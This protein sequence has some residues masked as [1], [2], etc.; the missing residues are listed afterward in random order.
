MEIK[1]IF[2]E[3]TIALELKLI[4]YGKDEIEDGVTHFNKNVFP[5][6]LRA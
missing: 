5:Q 4:V 3:H 2:Q 1:W 6:L